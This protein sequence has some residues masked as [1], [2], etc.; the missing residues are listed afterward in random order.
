[1]PDIVWLLDRIESGP[2]GPQI[3]A[4]FDFDQVIVDCY[5][6]SLFFEPRTRTGDLGFTHNSL[7]H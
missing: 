3:G 6:A 2:E 1:M 5:S 4:F 7:S